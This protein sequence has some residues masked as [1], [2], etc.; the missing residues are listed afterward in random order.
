MEDKNLIAGI[1]LGSSKIAVAIGDCKNGEINLKSYETGESVGIRG[2]V[3]VDLKAASECIGRV[4]QRAEKKAKTEIISVFVGISGQHIHS[5][6]NEG[7]IS[8]STDQEEIGVQHLKEV[9][10]K[11]KTTPS[12][13]GLEVMHVLPSEFILDNVEGVKNPIGLFGKELKVKLTSVMGL[14]TAIQNAIRCI[15]LIG[16]DVEQVVV[17]IIA[18]GEAILFPEEKELGVGLIDL[19]SHLTDIAIYKGEYPAYL[20]SLPYGGENLSREIATRL[21]ISLKE[22]EDIKKSHGVSLRYLL[23]S[24]E[25]INL[26]KMPP[27]KISRLELAEIIEEKSEMLVSHILERIEN[28]LPF[29]GSGLV[30]TG[31]TSNLVG[32]KE[33]IEQKTNLPVRI[34]GIRADLLS[35][36]TRYLEL[37]GYAASL[38]LIVYGKR[39]RDKEKN[40]PWEQE[41][42]YDKTI[43]RVVNWVKNFF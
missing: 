24:N 16:L 34:G 15:N 17:N 32:L 40:F 7:K 26:G 39:V 30:L 2:G 18:T 5:N 22:A 31:G 9:I 4:I 14:T 19:G 37:N 41:N 13:L 36:A 38:G 25:E 33:V 11:A 1:D 42:I 3:V 21:H 6:N 29:L 23:G 10:S 43:G 20:S 27:K 8:L 35:E 28:F 12:S